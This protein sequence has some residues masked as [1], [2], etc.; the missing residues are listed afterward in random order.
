MKAHRG[1]GLVELLVG[2]AIG[3]FLLTGAGSLMLAQLREHRRLVLETQVQQ[4]VRAIA[5]L[6]RRELSTAG[7]WGEPDRGAW[8]PARGKGQSNPYAELALGDDGR[9]ISFAASQAAQAG[10]PNENN[11]LDDTDRKALRWR[12]TALE[13]RTDGGRFQPLNDP[14]TVAIR[15]FEARIDTTRQAQ[16]GLCPRACDG[17]SQCPPHWVVRTLRVRLQ[18]EATQDPAVRQ[19]LEWQTRLDADRIEG[20]CRP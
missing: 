8:S 12:Q 7:A 10:R 11:Q 20:S 13:F 14:G 3:L 5:A 19:E 16:E 9:S 2:L 17:W 1:M 6:L 15:H 4:D 18:A